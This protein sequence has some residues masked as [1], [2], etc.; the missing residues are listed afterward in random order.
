[1][2]QIKKV[3]IEDTAPAEHVDAVKDAFAR[4]GLDVEVEAAYGRRSLDLLPWAVVVV[5]AY[6]IKPFLDGFF[7]RMGDRAADD[8]YDGFKTLIRDIIEARRGTGNGNGSITLSD[9]DHTNVVVPSPLPEGV[10]EALRNLDWD[11]VR[12]DYLVW[13]ELHQDWR[14]P[15][16]RD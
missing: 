15:T 5:L 6:P 4:A 11:A 7:T 1:V 13:D 14:D 12:G 9:P 10:I 8:S 16:R 2:G 3:V